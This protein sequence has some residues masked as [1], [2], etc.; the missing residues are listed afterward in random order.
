MVI[1]DRIYPP[2]PGF[3]L[4]PGAASPAGAALLAVRE[5]R[6]EVPWRCA[7]M[8]W[9]SADC[10]IGNL[11]LRD[12]IAYFMHHDVVAAPVN[13]I[14]QAAAPHPWARRALVEVPAPLAGA[15]A[16]SGGF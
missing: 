7:V 11:V 4:Y 2:C 10:V 15:S 5:S 14:A 9:P 16:V 6:H 8:G 13:T 12:A 3:G 1:A